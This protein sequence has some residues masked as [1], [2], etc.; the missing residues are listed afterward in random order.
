MEWL[1]RI[2]PL[3]ERTTIADGNH[4]FWGGYFKGVYP[5]LGWRDAG[6][7]KM[8]HKAVTK[9]IGRLFWHIPPELTEYQWVCRPICG[10]ENCVNPR[11]LAAKIKE[12]P[13]S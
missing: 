6:T 3:I 9:I 10:F 2:E 11:H 12:G 7:G 13:Y 4:W 5:T 8:V 1:R